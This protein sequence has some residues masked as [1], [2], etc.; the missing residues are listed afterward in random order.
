MGMT[1]VKSEIHK[2][3]PPE[4]TSFV[5]RRQQLGEI[6]EMLSG[7]RLVTLTGVGGVGK[8]RLALKTAASVRRA[9]PDGVWFIELAALDDPQLLPHTVASA[10]DLHH[11]SEAPLADLADHLEDKR[12]LMV[13]D[14]CEHLTDSCAV[15]V[16]K[17]LAAAPGLHVLVTSRHVLGVEGEQVLA[18]P[19]LSTPANAAAPAGAI[20][21]YEAVALLVDR[22]KA[23]DREFQVTDENRGMVVELCRRLDGLPLALEL[24]AVWLRAL[25][26]AEILER[27]ED[28]FELLTSGRRGGPARQH[29][30]EA[31]IAWS[32]D[33]C[34]PE[35]QLLWARLSVF[36]GGFDLDATEEVCAGEGVT[37]QN[38]LPAL[39]GLVDKSIVAREHDLE[40]GTSWYRMLET[41]R[42]YGARRLSPSD[43]RAI[44][45]RHRE[46]YR[47]LANGFAAEFFTPQQAEWYVRMGREHGNF[48]A[49]LDFC[50]S[51][52][53]EAATA[54]DIAA[55]LWPWWHAG[56]LHEG[57]RYLLRGL[58]LSTEPTL[59]RGY[60]LFATS[61]LAIHL[62][63]F[64]RARALLA[65][66]GELGDRFGDELLSA[67]VK[68]GQGHA[69]LH[70]G[71]PA[72]AVPFLEA[73]R[74]AARRL[75]QP[76]DEWRSV[77]L[78]SL[79]MMF[80]G[81]PRAEDLSRQ[82]LRLAEEHAA[83]SSKGWSL[84]GLGLAQW[85]A[86]QHQDAT[87]SLRNGIR[88]FLPM[89]N[90]NGVSVCVEALA[91]CAAT[92]CP[93][94]HAARLLG[95]ADAVW[96][97]IGGNVS[98]AVYRQFDQRSE[99]QV[100]SAIGDRRFD[101]AFAEGS[102]YSA[103]QAVALALSQASA[104][105][106]SSRTTATSTAAPGGLTR[107]EWEIAQLLA[108]GLSNKDIATRLVIAPRTA[109]TH[110]EHILT[111]L[112][113]TSRTQA[114]SWVIGQQG[115]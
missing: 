6:R 53:W 79:A 31:A 54:L 71:Q 76:R 45:L 37:R 10:L 62:S 110:V 9:F 90:L 115:H 103:D 38:V 113:F 18:V 97:T 94:E 61:N 74:D 50:L 7:S 55:P 64:D 39:A 46:R 44:R 20:S 112:G 75:G 42:Q 47:K 95:A 5:G 25:S 109:E 83:E 14:N 12:L 11:V 108:E 28:R 24:A 84:W 68:Q 2:A 13:L 77:N 88:L 102:A 56:H 17:L 22:T 104:H 93:D 60:G 59:S 81:D 105:M 16:G 19:P 67:R 114:S 40:H 106:G 27:L 51:E 52:P 23:V 80:L 89:R 21:H 34:S 91:W 4:L 33:L 29:A 107:R 32:F 26:P 98:Q 92:S 63:E 41:I 87:S 8:T 36:S 48:R 101:A 15:V 49:A 85:R 43:A 82:A 70:S 35:E 111:K 65:E 72:E 73:A 57:Y 99:E 69:L 30:L 96:A 1:I 66:A 78:H 3:L 100:R 86:G 58:E